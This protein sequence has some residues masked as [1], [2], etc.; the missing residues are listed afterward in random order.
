MILND[1][2]CVKMV[3][4]RV[5]NKQLIS[6]VVNEINCNLLVI[7]TIQV[8]A[9]CITNR[10]IKARLIIASVYHEIGSLI[11]YLTIITRYKK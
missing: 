2:D 5:N 1:N 7:E 11:D 4:V 8:D 10:W 6:S 9:Y 3:M